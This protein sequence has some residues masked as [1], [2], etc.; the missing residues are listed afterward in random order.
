MMQ[1]MSADELEGF[2]NAIMNGGNMESMMSIVQSSISRMGGMPGMGAM[3]GMGSGGMPDL[4][5]LSGL[6]GKK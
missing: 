2:G 4:S 6:F 1:D 5:M 3:P